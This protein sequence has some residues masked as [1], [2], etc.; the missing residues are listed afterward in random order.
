[1]EL[2]GGDVQ[3]HQPPELVLGLDQPRGEIVRIR[4]RG[5]EALLEGGLGFLRLL[6]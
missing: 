3:V 6:R 1:M 5:A 4:F 2:I